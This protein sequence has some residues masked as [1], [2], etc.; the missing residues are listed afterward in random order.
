MPPNFNE[1]DVSDKRRTIRELPPLDPFE[2]DQ[3]HNLYRCELESLLAVDDGVQRIVDALAASGEL[4]STLLM[5]TSDNGMEHGEHRI[6]FGKNLPY[7]EIPACR[8]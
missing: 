7:E 3:I 2:I 1:A 4:D 5:F 8:C 6:P